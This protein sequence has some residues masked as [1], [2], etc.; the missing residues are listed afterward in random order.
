MKPQTK[1]IIVILSV[2]AALLVVLLAG[3]LIYR[4]F[5]K[6]TNSGNEYG[7]LLTSNVPAELW[8]HGQDECE[9]CEKAMR[10][11]KEKDNIYSAD[12]INVTNVTGDIF[13]NA[14][15]GADWQPGEFR[16]AFLEI[17]NT[18]TTD[19]KYSLLSEVSYPVG[20]SQPTGFKYV[21]LKDM[22]YK[23]C[24]KAGYADWN[25]FVKIADSEG[26]ISAGSGMLTLDV[27]VAVGKSSYV[28]V[29]VYYDGKSPAAYSGMTFDVKLFCNSIAQE[30]DQQKVFYVS[31]NGHDGNPGTETAPLK[32]F[33]RAAQLAKPG[34]T[35]IFEDGVYY[36]GGMTVMMNS[37]TA[38]AP[39]IFKA[40]NQGEAKIIYPEILCGNHKIYIYQKEY[41]TIE[42]FELTQVEMA[43]DTHSNA[44]TD[45][46]IR[47]ALSN[48]ITIRNNEIHHAWEEPI[49]MSRGHNILIEGNYIHDAGYEAIDC[50]NLSDSIIRD[51]VIE[52]VGRMAL[53]CKGGSR[54]NLFYNNYLHSRERTIQNAIGIGGIS[55]NT[56]IWGGTADFWEAFNVYVFN[57]VIVA[58]N[59]G[60]VTYGIS[61]IG[62]RDCGAFNN[63]LVGCDYGVMYRVPDDMNYGWE[64][65][66][67]NLNI[68]FK[69]NVIMDSVISACV[70]VDGD[71]INLDSDYNLYYN[72]AGTDPLEPNSIYGKDPGF[73]ASK[74]DWNLKEDSPLKGAGTPISGLVGLSGEGFFAG[75]DKNYI[76]RGDTWDIGIYDTDGTESYDPGG[77]IFNDPAFRNEIDHTIYEAPTFSSMPE[78]GTELMKEEFNDSG[79]LS[80]WVGC[81]N[82]KGRWV[83]SGG[84]LT[85]DSVSGRVTARYKTGLTWSDYEYTAK[86]LSPSMTDLDNCSGIIFRADDEMKNMYA[87]R[88]LPGAVTNKLEFCMWNNGSFTSLKIVPYEWEPGRMY[89]LK[90]IA[91]GDNFAFYIE[92][93]NVFTA[94]DGNHIMGTVGVYSYRESHLFDDMLVTSAKG[95]VIEQLPDPD[96]IPEYTGTILLD[97][98]FYDKTVLNDWQSIKGNWAIQDEKMVEV[99]G[100]VATGDRR[101]IYT[102]GYDWKNYEV[103]VDV[104]LPEESSESAGILFSYSSDGSKYYG[105]RFV[106][107]NTYVFNE[108]GKIYVEPISGYPKGTVAKLKAVVEDDT[109]RIYLNSR[110][111][112]EQ[113]DVETTPGTIGL[114]LNSSCTINYFDNIEVYE[115]ESKYTGTGSSGGSSSGSSNSGMGVPAYKPNYTGNTLLNM[116]FNTKDSLTD[117]VV[118]DEKGKRE[119]KWEIVDGVLK[120]TNVTSTLGGN[121]MILHKTANW[122]RY[123]FGVDVVLP[124]SIGKSVGVVLGADTV[125]KNYYYFRIF[126]NG[127]AFFKYLYKVTPQGTEKLLH[128]QKAGNFNPGDKVRI[129]VFVE[130]KNLKIYIGNQEAYSG[131]KLT[132]LKG[133]IG[134]YQRG[135]FEINAFD[136]LTVK[137]LNT[138]PS[139]APLLEKNFTNP[140]KMNLWMVKDE[141]G[142]RVS[143]W[144]VVNGAMSE[145]SDATTDTTN[146]FSF[147][148][149]TG[150][151]F[152]NYEYSVDVQLP[153]KNVGAGS[154][155]TGVAF[156]FD[157]V[158]KYYY[159]LRVFMLG[160]DYYYQIVQSDAEGKHNVVPQE[161][162]EG[163]I[164]AGSVARITV[165]A[166]DANLKVYINDILLYEGM[167]P[168]LSGHIGLYVS[169]DMPNN[170]FDNIIVKKA[171]TEV[172]DGEEEEGNNSPNNS[173][174]TGDSG[175][176]GNTGNTGYTPSYTGTTLL[177][178]N[179]ETQGT[180]TTDWLVKDDNNR[181]S[182][183]QIA[184][185]VLTETSDSSVKS[186]TSM[187]I[188][189]PG[190]WSHYEYSVDVMMPGDAGAAGGKS[191]GLVFG[192]N[193]EGTSYYY[194]RI[195]YNGQAF[196]KYLYKVTEGKTTT[197]VNAQTVYGLTTD[198]MAN[199]KVIVEGNS[200]KIYLN[201]KEAYNGESLED[202]DG[203]I[204]LYVRGDIPGN[205]FD[206]IT[207]KEI[208]GNVID[209]TYNITYTN[210][211]SAT[212]PNPVTY[213]VS[214]ADSIILS[215]PGDRNG[216]TFDG[217][218]V[219]G[220]KIESL[221]GKTGALVI[222]AR[223]TK[224]P[225]TP[226]QPDNPDVPC[227]PS[228]SDDTIELPDVGL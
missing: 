32:S 212:N 63:V 90:V 72:N 146:G 41:I 219:D 218:F 213:K 24:V 101:I 71:P 5:A 68:I 200:L 179:F 127:Q 199:I 19:M 84:T 144:Q 12:Y 67:T 54:S 46:I 193:A 156:G 190:A 91:V 97:E 64:W 40:R 153:V 112:W 206:N 80:N 85:M 79:A 151:T 128:E 25:A 177:N 43:D 184:N 50:V 125:G 33:R 107:N 81:S 22:T 18:G 227:N 16:V 2:V 31:P 115:I 83:V 148:V 217:W 27:T 222:E 220:Q 75:F 136:N 45:M 116:D 207:V 149:Y 98:N 131:E 211:Y 1:K 191:V 221:A 162:I 134:L 122:N 176:A 39:I 55:N 166:A 124:D 28:A 9:E 174:N 209:V 21:F 73:V 119:S 194:F 202:L 3:L 7:R 92:D 17:K 169:G 88:F 141:T 77:I 185:G 157:K 103:W 70:Y 99:G 37:G 108:T 228:N 52:E 165:Y 89:E 140:E 30:G 152:T 76:L 171:I 145:T 139:N 135:V 78:Q 110:K 159:Y 183:W 106:G 105:F 121:T 129:T 74:S 182:N 8:W 59:P 62:A 96:S 147:L 198:T 192:S 29:V 36:E 204:G 138:V 196:V 86:V 120:D 58:D 61:F 203:T 188:Y 189:K 51:N 133:T 167:E 87:L 170:A 173:G 168:G 4:Q 60:K 224:K 49:K 208:V 15:V 137:E 114:Y 109:I 95:V 117:W 10:S 210:L 66:P 180:L 26:T 35:Y 205:A 82:S 197:I 132:G 172:D 38:D 13:A 42:G 175:N 56:S 104:Y 178:Q 187:L 53:M 181:L 57:N 65:N 225:D 14:P 113:K 150:Q 201:N 47:C 118:V 111:L 186:G 223:W 160:N 44:K 94:I 69:N 34:E 214:E 48:N 123:E 226:T 158:G 20:A 216:Y 163:K 130:N 195:M 164:E 93:K 102:K 154:K 215:A 6:T 11:N 155:S 143:N 126:Y 161:K 142:K 23:E 100:P